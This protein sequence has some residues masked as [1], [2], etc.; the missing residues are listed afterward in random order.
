MPDINM[1]SI[2]P[3]QLSGTGESGLYD[4]ARFEKKYLA[5]GDSWFSLGH[6]PPWSTTNLLQQM[7]LSRSAVAVNCARPGVE[8]AH[9]TDTSTAQT[10]L[11]L[12]N[13][14]VAWRWDAVLISGGGN[15]LIDAANTDPSFEPKLRLLLRSDEWQPSSPA[16]ARYLSDDG[17]ST[18]TAHMDK[19]LQLLLAQRDKSIN[20]GVQLLLHTYDYLTPRDAPAGPHLGPWL[21]RALHEQY[22]VPVGDWNIVADEL[23]NRLATMWVALATK[24]ADRH[25]TIV[26]TRHSTQR[27]AAGSH[28][29]S[30]DWE[31]EIHP[32]PHGYSLLDRK[33]RTLLDA[34]P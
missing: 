23:I 5:Q 9:M 30:N 31:N 20:Q 6:L 21:Y 25:I 18:F 27:A 12:L 8:L 15:D 11:N 3:S 2:S 16:P 7:V 33:W 22:Q 10:F 13:G 26:D 29:I 17:W 32:T 24:Y 1:I 28:G 34:L 14:K 19:V 4:V